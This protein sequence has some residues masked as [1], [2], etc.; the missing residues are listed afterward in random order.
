MQL[1]LRLEP[2]PLKPFKEELKSFGDKLQSAVVNFSER[3]GS[4]YAKRSD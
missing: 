3:L 4:D 1:S 2:Q